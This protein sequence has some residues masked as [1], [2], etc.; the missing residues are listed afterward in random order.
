MICVGLSNCTIPSKAGHFSDVLTAEEFSEVLRVRGIPHATNGFKMEVARGEGGAGPPG[1]ESSHQLSG[2]KELSFA[3]S[4]SRH[5][6]HFPPQSLQ[7]GCRLDR[8]S[9]GPWETP[10]NGHSQAHLAFR[11]SEVIKF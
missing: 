6:P 3:N 7:T 9:F 10:R 1:A 11:H 5:G 2:R 4:L 8:H